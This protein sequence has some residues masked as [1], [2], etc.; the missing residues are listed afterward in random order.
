MRVDV[1]GGNNEAASRRSCDLAQH[2]RLHEL[3]DRRQLG[4]LPILTLQTDAGPIEVGQG[5]TGERSIC[6]LN[7]ILLQSASP[8]LIDQVEE[9]LEQQYIYNVLVKAL[10]RTKKH[11][12]MI[13]VTHNA[14][15]PVLGDIADRN[16]RARGREGAGCTVPAYGTVDEM[17]EW[18]ERILDGGREDVPAARRAVRRHFP[19]AGGAGDTRTSLTGMGGAGRDARAARGGPRGGRRVRRARRRPS[20]RGDPAPPDARGRGPDRPRARPVRGGP[21][22]RARACAGKIAKACDAF[23]DPFFDATLAVLAV[24]ND[25]YVR[26]HAR[27]AADR[28]ATK[29]K[30]RHKRDTQQRE[31]DVALGAL[32]AMDDADA[33]GEG[34]SPRRLAERAVRQGVEHFMAQ[35]DHELGKVHEAI[36]EVAS[37][38][39]G[40]DRP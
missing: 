6:V 13:L 9:G 32:G 29:K 12:Q 26:E 7:L 30:E 18:L 39:R 10:R 33:R 35:L 22:T 28:H 4:D 14:F 34:R 23:P 11:R 1:H 19:S 5:S 8:L 21:G 25:P 40:R 15:V 17:R 3:P 36:F 38:P 24:D 16:L 20:G 27:R 37:P 2:P 31:L